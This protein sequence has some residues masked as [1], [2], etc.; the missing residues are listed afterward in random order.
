MS[1]SIGQALL[2]LLEG[3][4]LEVFGPVLGSAASQEA[5]ANGDPIK[6]VTAAASTGT[7]LIAAAP[8]LLGEFT[9]QIFAALGARAQANIAGAAAKVTAAEQVLA[10]TAA[11][12]GQADAAKPA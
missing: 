7:A 11:T 8:T 5:A 4:S 12:P 6:E 10:G 9:G 3:D 2:A 1:M